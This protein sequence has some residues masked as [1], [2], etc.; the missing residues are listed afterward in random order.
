MKLLYIKEHIINAINS[1]FH[2]DKM[3]KML[4]WVRLCRINANQIREAVPKTHIFCREAA[5][6]AGR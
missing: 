3:F 1:Y 6:P 2:S 5:P 4:F